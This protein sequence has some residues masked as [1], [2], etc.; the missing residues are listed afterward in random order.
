MYLRGILATCFRPSAAAQVTCGVPDIAAQ[1]DPSPSDSQ[2]PRFPVG[3]AQ[4]SL[5]LPTSE[6]DAQEDTMSSTKGA[7]H[8]EIEK[9]YAKLVARAW[10]DDAFRERL[11][12]NP[13]E[14]LREFGFEVPEGKQLKLIE[15]D[16]ETTI[17]FILPTRPSGAFSDSAVDAKAG[18]SACCCG[19]CYPVCFFSWVQ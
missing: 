10:A 8:Q 2:V 9:R 7:S 16:T 12:S 5:A 3:M 18:I 17:Y 19:A 14:V 11:I 6:N 1:D 4:S 15:A 13:E